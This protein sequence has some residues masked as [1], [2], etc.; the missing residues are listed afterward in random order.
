VK[1]ENINILVTIRC[2]LISYFRCR[3]REVKPETIYLKIK[4]I[5]WAMEKLSELLVHSCNN[6]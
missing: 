3:V 4:M 1:S 6:S 2:N 5:I